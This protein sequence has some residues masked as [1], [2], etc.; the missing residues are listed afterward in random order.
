MAW[1]TCHGHDGMRPPKFRPNRYIGRRVIAFP[2][3]SY[4]A[5]GPPTKSTMRLITLS[6]FGADP[7]L[8][9]R[10]RRYCDFVF[11]SLAEKCLTTLPFGVVGVEPLKMR[12]VI[13]T[14]K[15]T[16]LGDNASF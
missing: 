5:A 11:T 13:K 4:M 8:N 15:G 9:L 6:K 10:S 12:F 1:R 3:F 16:S 14:I 7:I 2:T